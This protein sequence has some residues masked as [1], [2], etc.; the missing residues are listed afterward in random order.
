MLLPTVL[1]ALATVAIDGTRIKDESSCYTL[2]DNRSGTPMAL[3]VTWQTIRRTMLNGRPVLSVLIHQSVG[4]GKFDMRDRFLLDASDLRPITFT[5]DRN[6]KRHVTL[7]YA[8][9]HVRGSRG[10]PDGTLEAIDVKLPG[11]T[12]EGNLY[13]ILFAALPLADGG[14]FRVPY[15]QYDKGL[16]EFSVQVLGQARGGTNVAWKVDAGANEQ[17]RSTYL[18]G[19]DPPRELAY[20]SG[21]VS[22]ELG[23]DCSALMEP[24]AADPA[25]AANPASVS[26]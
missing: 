12:W 25:T 2:Y 24:A 23:G 9:G 20:S 19:R 22:Q 21:G 13:G 4:G 10:K 18:L 8:D 11:P 17:R 6:G 14:N 5:N 26:P 1:L 7:R 3:G 16:G 15:Y